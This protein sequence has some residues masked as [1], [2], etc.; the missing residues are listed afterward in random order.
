MYSVQGK[1]EELDKL[2]YRVALKNQI[3][4]INVGLSAFLLPASI[5]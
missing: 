3:M 1:K 4:F 5:S 2:L